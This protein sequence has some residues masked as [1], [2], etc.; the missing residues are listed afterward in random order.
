MRT[1]LLREARDVA[2]LLGVATGL[3]ALSLAAR[4]D[5]PWLAPAPPP[6]PSACADEALA[7]GVPLFPRM[8]P[9]EVAGALERGAITIVDA[10]PVDEFV[11]AHIPGA[12][13][14]PADEAEQILQSQTLPIPPDH[15]VVTY[16][17]E[18]GALGSEYLG[19]LLGLAA[20]C[21]EIHVLDGGWEAWLASGAPIEGE[22]WSG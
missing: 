4:P 9:R 2:L 13:S 15:L 5:L 14:L 10:R 16:C 7:A 1:A 8:G 21:R 11:R 6:E 22:M 12:I 20:G 19:R 3:G 17:G 18:D